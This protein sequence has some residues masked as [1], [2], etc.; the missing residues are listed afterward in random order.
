[1]P[2]RIDAYKKIAIVQTQEDSEEL[3]DEFIDR[4]G[5]PPK[6]IIG[7]INIS[8]L[9]NTAARLGITEISQRNGCLLFYIASPEM[10]QI[11]ALSANFKGRVMF[12]SLAKPY[13]SIKLLPHQKPELLIS[14]VIDIMNKALTAEETK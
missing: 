11:K 5:E 13:I 14:D 8:L 2:Q 6:A 7:L 12:N 9:R 10:S 3:I 1:M 4:Y